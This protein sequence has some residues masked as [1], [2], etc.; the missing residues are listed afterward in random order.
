MLKKKKATINNKLTTYPRWSWAGRSIFA[1]SVSTNSGS[2]RDCLNDFLLKKKKE[3]KVSFNTEVMRHPLN[4]VYSLLLKI[5]SD[6]LKDQN[7]LNFPGLQRTQK[8][9]NRKQWKDR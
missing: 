6:H 3:K 7:S 4:M 5:I 8:K 2:I 9:H 1:K